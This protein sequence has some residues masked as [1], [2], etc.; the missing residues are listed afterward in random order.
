MTRCKWFI[1]EGRALEVRYQRILT[2]CQLWIYEND[3]PLALHKVISLSE[4]CTGMAAGKDV[5]G[6]VMQSAIDDVESGK[7]SLDTPTLVA[8]E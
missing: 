1:H 6:R 8:A 4:V 3:R 2:M 5:I 7:L